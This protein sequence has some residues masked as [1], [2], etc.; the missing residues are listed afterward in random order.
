MT[1]V[2][3]VPRCPVSREGR[4]V[5][6]GGAW[7]EFRKEHSAACYWLPGTFSSSSVLPRHHSLLAVWS[8]KRAWR[9]GITLHDHTSDIFF[10]TFR[11]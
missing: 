3:V 9:G 7:P 2:A 5:R 1:P 8:S 4:E 6:G 11:I 10:S